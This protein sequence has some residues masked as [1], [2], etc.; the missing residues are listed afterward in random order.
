[1]SFIYCENTKNGRIEHK[2]E[3]KEKMI[4]FYYTNL[5]NE[6]EVISNSVNTEFILIPLGFDA[7]LRAFEASTNCGKVVD[8]NG[9]MLHA[10]NTIRFS[11][12][13]VLFSMLPR[14]KSGKLLRVSNTNL[15]FAKKEG[16]YPYFKLNKC[17]GI[18]LLP[19]WFCYMDEN[20]TYKEHKFDNMY[21]VAMD[22]YG[23]KRRKPLV[24]LDNQYNF[25]NMNIM[26]A[27]APKKF[28]VE[29]LI[30]GCRYMTKRKTEYLYLGLCNYSKRSYHLYAE[31]GGEDK[32]V[33]EK[34]DKPVPLFVRIYKNSRGVDHFKGE[35]I[36]DYVRNAVEY[37]GELTPLKGL[38]LLKM[39]ND[40]FRNCSQ[41]T[42]TDIKQQPPECRRRFDFDIYTYVSNC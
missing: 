38:S 24:L 40:D 25:V 39:S 19:A 36:I 32:V 4:E 18:E 9:E 21:R 11:D 16:E 17:C 14:S 10:L 20:S 23:D 13:D 29:D 35:S 33:E 12:K 1:M 3:T 22:R 30:P 31:C 37:Y 28:E 41:F 2:F 5:A 42:L 27:E 34:T 15:M 8:P 6:Y 7:E 26:R